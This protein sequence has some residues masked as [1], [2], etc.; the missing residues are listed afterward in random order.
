MTNRLILGDNLKVMSRLCESDAGRFQMAYLDPPYNTGGTPEDYADARDHDQ[1]LQF[2]GDRLRALR[3]LMADRG[4]VFVQID[5]REQAYLK[6]L[7]DEHFGRD[8]CLAHVV[9]KMS[10]LSGVKMSHAERR[11]PKVKEHLLIYGMGPESRLKNLRRPKAREVLSGYLNYYRKIIDNPEAPPAQWELLSI[12]DWA[13]ARGGLEGLRPGSRQEA[14]RLEDLKLQEAHRV[15]YRTNN[16]L[17]AERNLPGIAEVFG[18]SGRRYISWEGKQILFLADHIDEPLS[19]LW[20]DLSTINLN[21]EGVGSFRYSKKPEALLHRCLQLATEPGDWVIDPFCGSG[22]T[23]AVAHKMGRSWLTI[24]CEDHLLSQAKPRLEAVMA[25]QDEG[26]V[27][28][29]L[30][31]SGGGGFELIRWTEVEDATQ[32]IEAVPPN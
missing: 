22:T 8:R 29:L 26:G 32:V 10:E 6:V 25:G 19:D 18:P 9:V 11:L 2:I 30:N 3:P 15:V 4:V 24:D 16:R 23:A 14:K 20:T 28:G 7:M 21:K 1:W 27:T 13:K 12:K 17:L 31:W 5:D